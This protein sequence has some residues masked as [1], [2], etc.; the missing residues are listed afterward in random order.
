MAATV[1]T[2]GSRIKAARDEAGLT[3]EQLGKAIG[4]NWR[5]VARYERGET[6][7]VSVTNLSRIARVTRKPLEYFITEVAA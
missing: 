4:V 5:T 1:E 6:L 2:M 7:N 3:R